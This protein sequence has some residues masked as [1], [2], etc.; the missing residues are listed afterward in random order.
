MF[1]KGISSECSRCGAVG[2]RD[3][4]KFFCPACG[5]ETEEKVN[6][7]GNVKKRGMK[8]ENG[9]DKQGAT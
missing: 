8:E 9:K 6:T 1:G 4:G 2:K 3:M 5:Y 7:A